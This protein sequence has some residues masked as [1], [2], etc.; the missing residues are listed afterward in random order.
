MTRRGHTREP[1]CCPDCHL[2]YEELHAF[3]YLPPSVRAML[4]AQHIA[5]RWAGFPKRMM[6][7]HTRTEEPYYRKYCP[8]SVVKK[9]LDD[10]EAL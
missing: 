3:P 9:V 4:S 1:A 6:Q 5:L 10:H 2:T 7:T 8:Q